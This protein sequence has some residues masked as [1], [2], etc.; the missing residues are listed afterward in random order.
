MQLHPE[1]FELIKNGNKTIELRLLD[2]KRKRI[3]K[4][5]IILFKNRIT[6]EI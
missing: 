2:E 3:R 5:D 6:E 1:P 4:G